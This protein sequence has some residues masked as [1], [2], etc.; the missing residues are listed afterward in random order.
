MADINW[1][2]DAF[3]EDGTSP[4]KIAPSAALTA[5]GHRPDLANCSAQ[6]ENYL[7][8]DL[9]AR[10]NR[11]TPDVQQ[12]SDVVDVVETWTKPTYAQ[13]ITFVL[14]NAGRNG[15]D[16]AAGS[17][18]GGGG[19]A[20]T[21]VEITL[22]ADQVPDTLTVTVPFPYVGVS[23]NVAGT[24]FL[25][26]C[27]GGTPTSATNGAPPNGGTWTGLDPSANPNTLYAGGAGGS[28]AAGDVPTGGNGVSG[29]AGATGIAGAGGAGGSFGT[30]YAKGGT[31]GRGYGAG[32]GGGGGASGGGAG[33]GGGGGGAGG[34][35]KGPMAGAGAS[36][37]AG[38][39]GLGGQGAP[40]IASITSWCG[41]DRG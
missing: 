11:L 38:G 33:G 35:G 9:C 15:A 32:G 31:G 30:S 17:N 6:E 12:F 4:T 24:N 14:V 26:T 16:G 19:A 7:L 5:K 36:A 13:F 40:G 2:S 10:V 22:P 28:G 3:Y 21:R 1:A 18:G 8:Y 39:P 20:G 29:S 23:T 25:L 37:T 34:W 41:A 27:A